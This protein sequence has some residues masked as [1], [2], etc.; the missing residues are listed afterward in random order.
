MHES[1][2]A[3][4]PFAEFSPNEFHSYVSGMWS[5][6]LKKGPKSGVAG[7]SVHRTK[8]GSLSVRRTKVRPFAYVTFPELKVLAERAA[9]SQA[10][11]WNVLKVKKFF[12]TQTRMEA[13]ILY[14]K[15]KEMPF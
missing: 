3:P 11:L 1:L 5:M 2:I 10:E 13:E 15:L 9:C 6:P 7:L 4:K 14:A 8:K 12:I